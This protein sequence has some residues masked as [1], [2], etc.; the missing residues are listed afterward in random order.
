MEYKELNDFELLTFV[1]ENSEEANNLLF[2]K[3]K[4]L[5]EVNARRL[6]KYCKFNGLEFLDLVQEGM[7]G[8]S[9]AID[10]FNETKQTSFYTYAKTCIERK[11]LSLIV[12]SQRQKH[13]LLNESVPFEIYDDGKDEI[14]TIDSFLVDNSYNPENVVEDLENINELKEK[15]SKILTSFEYEVFELKIAGFN[16]T[17]IAEILD[18]DKKQI[19]NAIQR[20][21]S[22]IKK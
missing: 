17:E 22:K 15:I 20:I 14:K 18:K 3:Y 11:Q 5:I 13:K 16:Y 4:P 19:D 6:L 9:K 12:S 10:T 1:R 21:K 7:L 2:K 8:L